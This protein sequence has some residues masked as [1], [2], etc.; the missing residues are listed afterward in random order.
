M[1]ENWFQRKIWAQEKS[2]YHFEVKK[3]KEREKQSVF[4]VMKEKYQ[5]SKVDDFERDIL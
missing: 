1:G 5:L 3:Y 4:Q 2:F